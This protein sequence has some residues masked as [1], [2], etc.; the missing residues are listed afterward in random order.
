MMLD[1]KE[2]SPTQGIMMMEIALL[3]YHIHDGKART[4]DQQDGLGLWTRQSMAHLRCN[5]SL[6]LDQS[7][8]LCC[9]LCIRN[10]RKGF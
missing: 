1:I 6:W 3:F 2:I 10:D 7:D 9:L 8:R 4:E 5:V